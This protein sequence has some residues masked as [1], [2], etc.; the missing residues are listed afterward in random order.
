MVGWSQSTNRLY[1]MI[2]QAIV[3]KDIVVATYHGYVREMCPHILG[4]KNGRLQCLMYQF[5]GGSSSA[6]EADGSPAN[7]R[8]IIVEELLNVSIKQ[9]AGQWHTASN[10][11]RPQ[12]CVNPDERLV[13][14]VDV[15]LVYSNRSR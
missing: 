13:E 2:R 15:A 11:S 10:Y 3:D 7:W 5:G 14:F 8:C 1:Q 12:T 4:T 6:L 9:S